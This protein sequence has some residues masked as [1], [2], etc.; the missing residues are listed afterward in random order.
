[1]PD[2]SAKSR[3]G[4]RSDAALNVRRILDAG[5]EVLQENPQ[6]SAEDVAR[7]AGLGVATLYRRFPTREDLLRAVVWDIFDTEMAP[8]LARAEAAEDPRDGVRI[9][10]E[11]GLRATSRNGLHFPVGITL[12]II[13][14]SFI[15]PVSRMVRRAQK[16]RLMRADL[17]PEK[18]MLRILLMLLSIVPTLNRGSD[19]W[20][21]YLQMVMDWLMVTPMQILPPAEA[22]V[23]PFPS[24]R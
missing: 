7:A 23:D 15:D 13:Q 17:E 21:R 4:L 19:G 5:R 10:F 8:A 9:A 18:D 11:E 2:T 1:M 12:E 16:Q 14:S 22:V 24:M 3:S 6:A 20:M